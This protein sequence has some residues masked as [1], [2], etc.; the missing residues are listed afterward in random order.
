MLVTWYPLDLLGRDCQNNTLYRFCFVQIS[1]WLWN[2][3]CFQKRFFSCHTVLILLFVP[4]SI[5]TLTAVNGGSRLVLLQASGRYSIFLCKFVGKINVRCFHLQKKIY[6][7]KYRRHAHCNARSRFSSP[8]AL[9][10]V[11][12]ISF[13]SFIS[14]ILILIDSY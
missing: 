6:R 7:K 9:N 4:S 14:F 13:I 1:I 10:Q 2:K 8:I 3:E 11:I 5:D 12:F